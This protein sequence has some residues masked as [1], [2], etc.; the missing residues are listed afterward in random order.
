MQSLGLCHVFFQQARVLRILL[1]FQ[2]HAHCRLVNL[3]G[4]CSFRCKETLGPN[5]YAQSGCKEES[6]HL[7]QLL[8]WMIY[9]HVQLHVIIQYLGVALF[10]EEAGIAGFA[11]GC[12]VS[13]H[14]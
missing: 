11:V 10:N 1:Y 9:K 14:F 6:G 2:G 4:C 3:W 12:N 7:D 8:R 13:D 5:P